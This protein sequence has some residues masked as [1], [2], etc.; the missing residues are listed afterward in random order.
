MAAACGAL[1][2]VVTMG[3]IRSSETP[4]GPGTVRISAGLAAAGGTSI[5][6]PP[7]GRLRA[8][9]HRMPVALEARVA[10]LDVEAAQRAASGLDPLMALE[11][12]ITA[13]LPDALRAFALRTLVIAAITGAAAAL[14]LPGR[15]PVDALAGGLG[16]ILAVGGVLA[17]TW[18]PYDLEAFREPTFE[19]E[20]ARVPGL[21]TA[22]ERNL[23]DLE[24][25]RSR[26]DTVSDRLAELYA[27]S[28]GEL[29]G[30]SAGET[31]I[32]HVSDLHLNP[33]GAEL[34]VRLAG[35]LDV[36]AILD[37]GDATSF[38]LPIEAR[39]GEV[40]GS[41]PV[42][43]YLVPGNHDSPANRLQLAATEGVTVLDGDVVTVGDVKI[44][45]VPDPTFTADNEVS[46]D[47]ARAVKLDAAGEVDRLV[48]REDPD[49]LAV[50]DLRQAEESAGSVALI[51]GG[52]L[53]ERTEDR[54]EGTL[55]LTVGSIGA[56][57][58]GS[59]T[60]ETSEPYE[61][62][63]L[64]F[65]DGELVAIDYLTVEG[66]G[67]DFILERRLVEPAEDR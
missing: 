1:A 27:A 50:H 17:A 18:V 24:S 8:D 34:V 52:H 6:L 57:G 9:T 56:T 37:T 49:V 55:L 46:T 58:L 36:D 40:L 48:R 25:V 20:L 15:R 28:L 42:P 59:F 47:D 54:R 65:R 53:H 67:G 12:Q 14:L 10:S 41:A 60:V 7:L 44:L 33:L 38:G 29:P 39:V 32:L 3:W 43:Y 51:V 63:V 30:G 26:I 22:A 45:G 2:A 19:G 5:E 66:I 35:D 13:D 64:R 31:S 4:L 21:I 11:E 62:Q 16:A 23:A 61:A